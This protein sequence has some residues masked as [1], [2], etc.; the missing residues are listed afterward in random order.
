MASSRF[1][2]SLRTASAV[3]LQI[4]TNIKDNLNDNNSTGPLKYVLLMQHTGPCAREEI[5][6]RIISLKRKKQQQ[7]RQ[8]YSSLLAGWWNPYTRCLKHDKVT[9]GELGT[10]GRLGSA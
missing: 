2:L 5:T 6:G 8:Q 7:Q 3:Q 10:P 9:Q 4:Q 1:W